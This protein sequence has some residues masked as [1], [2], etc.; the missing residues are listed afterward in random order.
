MVNNYVTALKVTKHI[1]NNINASYGYLFRKN[2]SLTL[3]KYPIAHKE[4]S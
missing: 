2:I 4:E 3:C 1:T